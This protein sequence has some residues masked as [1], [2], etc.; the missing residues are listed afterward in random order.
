MKKAKELH[1]IDV[2]IRET[3]LRKTAADLFLA[4]ALAVL[5]PAF[6]LFA[7]LYYLASVNVFW[8]LLYIG[9]VAWVIAKISGSLRKRL[10]NNPGREYNRRENPPPRSTHE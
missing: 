1:Y 5:V 10:D 8:A 9:G 6:V 4:I 3:D 2:L 7:G